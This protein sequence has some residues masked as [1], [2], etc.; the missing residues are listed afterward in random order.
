M[1]R[2][3]SLSTHPELSFS[4]PG[5]P[6]D[7]SRLDIGALRTATKRTYVWAFPRGVWREVPP[8]V[9]LIC[10]ALRRR[11]GPWLEV[12]L[13]KGE[14]RLLLDRTSE[15]PRKGGAAMPRASVRRMRR[16]RQQE[17]KR[18]RAGQRRKAVDFLQWVATP[19]DKTGCGFADAFLRG[20]RG[21]YTTGNA[22]NPTL[23]VFD[24]LALIDV[25]LDDTP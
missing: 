25:A 23:S 18:L 6:D 1:A 19:R 13:R 22:V 15:W 10:A 11:E 14:Y 4:L 8:L 20:A 3:R 12:R 21:R 5:I 9:A 16:W 7:G 2:V 24:G 17:A